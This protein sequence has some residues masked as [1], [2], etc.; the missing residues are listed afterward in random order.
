MRL[1]ALCAILPLALA[2]PERGPTNRLVVPESDNLIPDSYIVK[3]K[4]G[5][6][7]AAL[8]KVL[9]TFASGDVNHVFRHV[10]PGFSGKIPSHMLDALLDHPDVCMANWMRHVACLT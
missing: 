6:G 9:D 2:A 4:E 5:S 1:S 8:D 7:L 10:F 3:F